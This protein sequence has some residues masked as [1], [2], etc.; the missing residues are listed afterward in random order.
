MN[1]SQNDAQERM[2]RIE[3][4]LARLRAETALSRE[5][6]KVIS[7]SM[8]DHARVMHDISAFKRR[9]A[10]IRMERVRAKD[11]PNR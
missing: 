5:E 3:T 2:E 1:R 9:R 10:E 11:S 4:L 7:E 8:A 6:A